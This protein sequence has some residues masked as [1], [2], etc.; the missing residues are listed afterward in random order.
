MHPRT[1]MTPKSHRCRQSA[2]ASQNR[3]TACQ[4]PRPRKPQAEPQLRLLNR[5]TKNQAPQQPKLLI[6]HTTLERTMREHMDLHWTLALMELR[7]YQNTR[8][9]MKNQSLTQTKRLRAR[10]YDPSPNSCAL[11]AYYSSPVERTSRHH[12]T[13]L[14][15]MALLHDNRT[16]TTHQCPQTAHHDHMFPNVA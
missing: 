6:S 16:T 9:T 13:C 15:T 7:R 12:N 2:P 1:R 4:R 14:P 11:C 5:M 8:M 3:T 10:H